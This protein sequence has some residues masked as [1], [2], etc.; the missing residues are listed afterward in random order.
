M[1]R[2]TKLFETKRGHV[3]AGALKGRRHSGSADNLEEAKAALA[4][5]VAETA[6][7]PDENLIARN[8]QF[9][10]P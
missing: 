2:P 8:V 1:Q 3:A 5:C 9:G 10:V 6:L 4:G 7:M